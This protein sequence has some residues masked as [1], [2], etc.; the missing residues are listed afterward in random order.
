MCVSLPR[1]FS[2][3]FFKLFI[4]VF[5]PYAVNAY[6]AGGCG[7]VCLPIEALILDKAQVPDNQ[8]RIALIS[9][10]AKFDNFK[11]GGDSITNLGGNEAIITENT[12]QFDYG[13]TS[14]W[15]VS[16]LIPYVKKEQKTNR[17]GTRIAEGL[18]DVSVFTRYELLTREKRIEG[19]SISFGLGLKFPTGSI[20]EPGN[21][22]LLPPAFQ[23]GSGAYDLVPTAS[24]FQS[25]GLTHLFGSAAWRIPLEDNKRGYK[26]G[27]EFELNFGADYPSP[28]LSESLSFQ[29]ST[30]YLAAGKDTDS[31]FI[32]PSRL[33]NGTTVLNTGGNFLDISA[34]FRWAISNAFTFQTKFSFPVYE[35]WNGHRP[36]NVGQVTQDLTTQLTL[37]YTGS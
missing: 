23:T 1:L 9:E 19:Q 17:F 28:F 2:K 8:Y 4:V 11:E 30:S 24:F 32:L 29:L 21:A 14:R 15:N 6:A 3:S 33:R 5:I 22:P 20:D 35:S 10:Y 18:G 25:I 16:L 26:F 12:L 36:T 7:S 27:Q 37:I 31:N 34:G 13:L